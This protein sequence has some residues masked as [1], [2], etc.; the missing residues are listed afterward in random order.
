[1]K[2]TP[3]HRAEK[4]PSRLPRYAATSLAAT[5]VAAVPV[6]GM[7]APA[8]AADDSTWNKLAQCESGGTW[9]IN[10]GNGCYGGLHF[11]HQTWEAFGG[12]QYASQADQATRS[13]QIATAE[14]VLDTQGWGAWP[15]CSAKLG[16]SQAD[17]SGDPAAPSGGGTSAESGSSDSGSSESEQTSRSQSRT[18]PSASSSGSYTVK[19]GDT[20]SKI[21][22][23]Q[24][25]E[26]GWRAL[27]QQN[28]DTVSDP[29]MIY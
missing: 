5:A 2:Y 19:P 29:G 12:T 14:K 18:S 21:A 11:S 7:A 25:V 28:S 26:G 22:S 15:A 16:L 6:V 9:S 13:Q 4:R 27:Y 1:M 8:S 20:L 10:A 3:R 17:A 23:S 24:G